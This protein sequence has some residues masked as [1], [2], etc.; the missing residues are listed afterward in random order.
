MIKYGFIPR[1]GMVL[2]LSMP[3]PSHGGLAFERSPGLKELERRTQT[4]SSPLMQLKKICPSIDIHRSSSSLTLS[5]LSLSQ[6][7]ND[8]SFNS[9][10]SS[11]DHKL[12]FSLRRIFRSW[13]RRET[14]VGGVAKGRLDGAEFEL[15]KER[16]EE[17]EDFGRE[18]LGCGE[19]ASLKRCNWITKNSDELYVS[20]HDEC[21]GVP[22]YNDRRLFE[23]LALCGMLIDHNWTEILKRRELYRDAFSKFDYDVVVKMEENDVMVIS[24]NKELNLAESRVRCIIDNA[25]CIQKVAKEFGS[26]S[27]YIWG[28]MNHKPMVN[29]YKYPRSV[30]LRTPKAEAI[31]KDLVRRGFRLVGPVIVYSFMQATGMAIDHVVDCFRFGECVRMAQRSWGLTTMAA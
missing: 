1:C 4:K 16:E 27:R 15:L 30:P 3:T 11:L 8:S 14:S 23:L 7:S 24:S 5:S 22:V 28:Q 18:G 21:W 19:P 25:K 2:F 13:G 26:F 29:K 20:F 9:S 17:E 6:N 31:S 10:I 12:P